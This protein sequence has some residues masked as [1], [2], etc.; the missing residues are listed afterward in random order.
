MSETKALAAAL[1]ALTEISGEA[2]ER[3][4]GTNLETLRRPLRGEGELTDRI[5]LNVVTNFP[6]ML[7]DAPD[8][9]AWQKKVAAFFVPREITAHKSNV[10]MTFTPVEFAGE[11]SRDITWKY[12]VS[13][14]LPG[15]APVA[16]AK[17]CKADLKQLKYVMDNCVTNLNK[18]PSF[19]E[20]KARDLL[21]AMVANVGKP[22]R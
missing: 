20:A 17:T 21:A 1:A 7:P 14:Q 22:G 13:F 3:K 4:L 6:G 19:T 5:R 11:R 18:L 10:K 2:I 12:Q 15:A 16:L 8:Q 9:E